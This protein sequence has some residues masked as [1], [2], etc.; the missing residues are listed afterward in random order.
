M[1]PDIGKARR[2]GQS[3]STTEDTNGF[4]RPEF[5]PGMSQASSSNDATAATATSTKASSGDG[6]ST[7]SA[8]E[9]EADEVSMLGLLTALSHNSLMRQGWLAPV[10]EDTKD[11]RNWYNACF[12]T[13]AK[14]ILGVSDDSC[15]WSCAVELLVL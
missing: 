10:C 5:A 15:R 4:P 8:A 6:V 12:T 9:G 1:G 11:C 14:H 13:D 2:M 7:S 3:V